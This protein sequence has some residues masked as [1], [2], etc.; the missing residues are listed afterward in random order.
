MSKNDGEFL[1]MSDKVFKNHNKQLRLLRRRGLEVSKNG[2]PK[3]ILEKVNY[4]TLINGYKELFLDVTKSFGSDDYYINNSAFSEFHTLYNFDNELKIILLKRILRI[5]KTIKTE[6]AYLFSEIHGHR[7]YL[8]ASN[9]D[10]TS[11]GEVS[12]L[13]HLIRK[14]IRDQSNNDAISHYN[15]QHGYIPLWVLMTVLSFGRVSHFYANMKQPERQVISRK[16]N[17]SDREL[18]NFLKILTI[19]RNKSAHDERL[20]NIRIRTAIPNNAIHSRLGI[21]AV[22]GNPIMGKQDLFAVLII[23]KHLINK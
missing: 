19:I 22:S 15:S 10:N 1:A 13:I 11:S 5:E 7:N 6:I 17:I 18:K 21:P 3:R 2:A 4:Y 8:E 23:I 12:K 16:Y 14:D 9:F 20:Y